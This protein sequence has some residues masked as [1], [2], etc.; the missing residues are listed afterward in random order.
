[1]LLAALLPATAQAWG[2][3]GHRA[4]ATITA[5]RLCENAA[6]QVAQLLDDM[7]LLE[8]STWPDAIR[9]ETR[10]AHTRDWHYINIGDDEPFGALDDS[11]AGRGQLLIAIRA[12]LAVLAD[13]RESAPRRREALSF[14]VHLVADLHQPLHVGRSEDR[15]G[16]TIT[17]R[18]DGD[19]TNLHR[20]WDSA[21][22]R[23]TGLRQA[24]YLRTL[25]PLVALGAAAWEHGELEDWAEESRRLRPWVYDFDARRRVPLIS[26][27]Y[28]E[29]G[30]QIT[31]LRV[32][33]AGVRT[34]WVLN[35]IW[36]D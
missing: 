20:L 13:E 35:G 19:E 32:A 15:G 24:D 11:K 2:H 28:A 26:R 16:N 30:R 3:D 21:L 4:A 7:T 17:V 31:A 1:V 14:V 6:D 29:T 22:L 10:W 5:A 34:A 18:F 9:G 23:S 8:A 25:A 33:Q 12:N 36:C 27:R